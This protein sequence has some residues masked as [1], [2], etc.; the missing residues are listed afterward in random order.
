ML[1]ET[2]RQTARDTE[3][4]KVSLYELSCWHQ[5]TF[6]RV[7]NNTTTT[8]KCFLFVFFFFILFYFFIFIRNMLLVL[9]NGENQKFWGLS[10]GVIDE[11]F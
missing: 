9:E 10:S 3:T 6:T 4:H 2:H 11:M 1:L 8:N 7:E 5:M